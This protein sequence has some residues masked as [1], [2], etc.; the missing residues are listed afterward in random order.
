VTP[1]PQVSYEQLEQ[2]RKQI[3]RLVEEIARLSES[4]LA[5]SDYYGEFLQRVLTAVA[6]PAG[7]VWVRTPQ[8]H[9]QLQYQINLRQIAI[10]RSENDREMHAELLRLVAQNG[11]PQMVPPRSGTG[12]SEEGKPAPGN[13]SD[14]VILIAPILVDKQVAGLVEIWQDADRNP[15]AQQGF[16]Q[17]ITRMAELASSY[18]RNHQ[19]RQ[20][21]GQQT[22]WTQ[23][24]AFARQIHSSLNPMEVGYHVANEGRRLIDCDRVSV[25]QRRGKKTHVEAI[26]GADIVEKRSNLVRLMATLFDKV[27][28]WGEKLIY[29]G[30][31]DD[32]LPPAV[33]QALDAYLA[34]SN[35]KLLVVLPLRDER[36]SESKKPPRSAI[37]MECFD[38]AQAPEQLVA[39]LEVVGRH[40]TSAL[41]NAAEHR[42]IPMRFIWQP[43]A[44]VQE[45]LGGKARAITFSIIAGLV[46]LL[47]VFIFVPYPLKMDAKGQL[48]PQD[49]RYIYAPEEGKIMSFLVAPGDTV[50]KDRPLVIMHDATLA[51]RMQKLQGDI[52]AARQKELT[53]EAE[54]PR[55]KPEQRLS[56]S[57]EIAAEAITRDLK[58]K[59]LNELKDLVHAMPDMQAGYFQVLSPIDGTVLNSN[60]REELTNKTIKPNEPILRLGKK[61]GRW[62]IELKIP[63]KHIGQVLQ[64]FETLK[65]DE[66][67]VDL[68]LKSLPTHTYRAKLA[69]KDIGGEATP[70]RDDNNEAEP[71]VLAYV[72]IEGDDI[73]DALPKDQN[74]RV[75]GTEVVA[76]VRCGP[77]AMGY[78][79][80][81]GVWEFFY[82]KIVFFF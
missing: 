73:A 19:L 69:R 1:N 55:T 74:L 39:R 54:L 5:P 81:Y 29:Q 22:L 11:R 33:L 42:R 26:S 51:E 2:T 70:N 16:L 12:P 64:A 68:I 14:H 9:L 4:D 32:S 6:A 23:L 67:D 49:R 57:G 79:L 20:M 34:E 56:L 44:K 3:N 30:T 38:P 78:S 71:I 53:L 41:Y 25:G 17:F 28:V 63:Q 21:V 82:E 52:D 35:S 36:E 61:D 15:A 77:H 24:E 65:T 66:L 13:P 10:D 58:T 18:T 60:F 27:L 45:G 48:L 46:L 37:M 76:K 7:A 80:F 47:L 31:K 8:G 40:A 62:E 75:T 43:I 50:L 72:R 59:E